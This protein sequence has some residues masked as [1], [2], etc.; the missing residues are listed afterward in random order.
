ME[1]SAV[2]HAAQEGCWGAA[3]E[4]DAYGQQKQE[5]QA[6]HI[7]AKSHFHTCTNRCCSGAIP[8]AETKHLAGLSGGPTSATSA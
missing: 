8:K 4:V 1:G 7:S 5:S 6:C 3:S 2:A